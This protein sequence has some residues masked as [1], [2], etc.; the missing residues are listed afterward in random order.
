MT[1]LDTGIPVT[2]GATAERIEKSRLPAHDHYAPTGVRRRAIVTAALGLGDLATAIGSVQL[3]TVFIDSVLANPVGGGAVPIAAPLVLAVY[4]CLG[5]YAGRGPSPVERLRLRAL[6][7][8]AF[9]TAAYI[10]AARTVA[11]GSLVL[12]LACTSIVMLMLGYYVEAIVRRILIRH[13]LWGAPTALFGCNEASRE[14][15]EMLLIAQPELGLRPVCFVNDLV[16]R[17]AGMGRLPIPII[18]S[19]TEA[20]GLAAHV[21]VAILAAPSQS[22][23]IDLTHVAR[24]PFAKVI[25]AQDARDMQRLRLHTRTSGGALGLGIPRDPR[26]PHHRWLKRLIDLLIAVPVG[27]VSL[28][29]IIALAAVI[30]IVD[31]GPA[32]Y[33]Q[34]RVGRNGRPLRVF[35]LRTMYTDAEQRLKDHLSSAPLARA[36]WERYVKLSNDPRVLPLF[37]NVLR[38]ASL[39]ELPQLWNVIRGEMSIVGPRPFPSYHMEK[40]DQNFQSLRTSVAQGLTGLWQVSSRSNGDLDVQKAQDLLY[41]QNWSIWL[42]LYIILETLPA[43]LNAKGAR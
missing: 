38:R 2:F 20:A 22:T 21:E 31:P 16:D 25:L 7:I 42:D 10:L 39:D 34:N 41:I 43:V 30:K 11:P 5:L 13:G 1:H 12:L 8:L 35:K 24:F 26:L 28:P 3:A 19:L 6:G 18:G 15:A 9:I 32:I 4:W 23:S 40:F 36:E 37:G 29:L 27:L 14:L 33:V 17:D